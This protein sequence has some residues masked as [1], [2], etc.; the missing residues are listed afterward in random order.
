MAEL[1]VDT[2]TNG[3]KTQAIN[4]SGEEKEGRPSHQSTSGAYQ[5]RSPLGVLRSAPC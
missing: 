2:K 1:H 4:L 3:K 5:E